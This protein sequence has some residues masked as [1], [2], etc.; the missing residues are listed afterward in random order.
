MAVLIVVAPL[1]PD[2]VDGWTDVNGWYSIS[3]FPLLYPCEYS[4][5]T[6]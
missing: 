4:K 5:V 3:L 2:N 1:A 6:P